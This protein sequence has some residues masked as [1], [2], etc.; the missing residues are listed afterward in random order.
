MGEREKENE[1]AG[2]EG[3]RAAVPRWVRGWRSPSLVCPALCGIWRKPQALEVVAELWDIKTCGMSRHFP[4]GSRRE[5]E[6]ER[7]EVWWSH[8]CGL[9][10]AVRRDHW[11]SIPGILEEM[12]GLLAWPEVMLCPGFRMWPCEP[13]LMRADNTLQA[14]SGSWVSRDICC[15]FLS[16]LSHGVPLC[17]PLPCHK[18][19]AWAGG[20][21]QTL[22]SPEGARPAPCEPSARSG[23]VEVIPQCSQE[24]PLKSSAAALPRSFGLAGS[25]PQ[26]ISH[27][28]F[29]ACPS[30]PCPTQT[31]LFTSPG[32]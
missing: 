28:V 18:H 2:G 8:C 24:V 25:I 7:S 13:G 11:R 15:L 14:E 4:V 17:F 31:Q 30:R 27:R 19:P 16:S 22:Q 23:E 20:R 1:G 29:P 9:A 21:N 5:R 32:R 10:S 12:C 6:E 3:R 26:R